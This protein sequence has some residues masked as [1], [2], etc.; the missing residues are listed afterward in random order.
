M[1][2]DLHAVLSWGP[3][4][5]NKI[6]SGPE[7][8]RKSLL[9]TARHHAQIAL[10]DFTK[11]GNEM[12]ISALHAGIAVEHMAKGY[13]S[14]LH[15]VLLA[16]KGCDMDTLLHLVGKGELAK[17]APYTIKTIGGIEAC[18]RAR[19]FCPEFRFSE[20]ADG[21]IFS[22]RN[23]VGHLGLGADIRKAIRIM[24]RLVEPLLDAVDYNR[25]RFWGN[26]L[27]T[28]DML[29]DENIDELQ[30]ILQMKYDAARDFLE[31]SFSGLEPVEQATVK[32]IMAKSSHSSSDYDKPYLCPVCG[33][34]GWLICSREYGVIDDEIVFN[35]PIAYPFHFECRVCN[36]DL[37][38]AEIEAAG[39]PNRID[40]PDSEIGKVL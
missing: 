3:L 31:A 11:D 15:P 18:R 1:N 32:A 29:Q 40:L 25:A 23:S 28:V 7:D 26:R 16:E 35:E 38:D 33:A 5:V 6:W 24:V 36:L 4:L 27:S 2:D 30:A 13:L 21:L 8:L 34:Q 20:Q 19:N 14:S 22:V 9:D 12:A 39:M 10:R 37:E 17:S